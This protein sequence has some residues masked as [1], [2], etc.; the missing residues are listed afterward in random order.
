MNRLTANFCR[1]EFACKC[2]CGFDTVDHALVEGLQE[3]RN[4]VDNAVVV[5]SGCRCV[6]RNAEIGGSL[7][8]QHTLGRAADIVVHGLPPERLAEIAESIPA[9]RHGGIGIYPD[10]VHV[11]TRNAKSR[12]RA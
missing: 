7:N 9:F 6:E 10:W 8:S 4:I 3:I 1:E 2:G 5:T 12:W 11:D